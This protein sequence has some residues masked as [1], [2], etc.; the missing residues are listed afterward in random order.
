MTKLKLS[1]LEMLVAAVDTGS[2]SA[3]AAAL[4]C[5]QSRISHAI[6]ELEAE[7]G[8]RLLSRSRLG[9]EPTD[10]GHSVV[11]KARQVLALTRSI[12]AVAPE[13]PMTGR[14]QIACFQSVGAHLL[15][16]A[17]AALAN[18]HPGI[19]VDLD[20]SCEEREDVERAVR[21]GHA[22]IG[23]AHLPVGSDLLISPF[24]TDS[25]V[26][27]VP[28]S[29]AIRTPVSW[30]QFSDL[31][32]IHLHCSGALAVLEKCRSDGFDAELSR[33]LATH[34]GIVAM[35]KQG[36][37]FSIL[38]LLAVFPEPAGVKVLKLPISAKRQLVVIAPVTAR[39][40][41]AK[42]VLRYVCERKFVTE[43]AA[44]RSGVVNW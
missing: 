38:P 17:L 43:S 26:L 3:A 21:G 37:G 16:R 6:A 13:D 29:L 40:K 20:E 31:P 30:D 9:C 14:V 12:S 41:A 7:L 2:F 19:R 1:Q 33:T 11:I 36:V 42:I 34:A 35:V 4:E 25:Y 28:A 22:D 8:S 18:E 44:F 24:V 5:T 39:T 32:Y 27:L 10:A 23:I 15:P